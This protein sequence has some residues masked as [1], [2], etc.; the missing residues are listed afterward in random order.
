MPSGYSSVITLP[1][2]AVPAHRHRRQ[3]QS[4]AD[5]V[6]M[7]P[8][9]PSQPSSDEARD[10]QQSAAVHGPRAHQLLGPPP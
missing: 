8:R 4:Y 9:H 10:I 5:Q 2:V 1:S 7:H 3:R 6:G